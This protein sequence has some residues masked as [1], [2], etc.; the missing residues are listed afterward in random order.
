MQRAA[1]GRQADGF[2]AAQSGARGGLR[3][4]HGGAVP[5]RKVNQKTTGRI[6]EDS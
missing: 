6:V 2:Y 5:E 1:R 4:R 3:R